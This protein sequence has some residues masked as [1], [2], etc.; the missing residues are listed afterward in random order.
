MTLNRQWITHADRN[1]WLRQRS[2]DL[3]STD[4]A[5]L[6]GFSPYGRS[7]FDLWHEK[8][9][10]DV[11]QI[12]EDSRMRRGKQ[13]ERAIAEMYASDY[14]KQY[15]RASDYCRIPELRIGSSFDF[16]EI[17]GTGARVAIWECKNVDYIAFKNG[18]TVTDDFIEAPPYIEF[19]VQH[20]MLVS[21]I[22]RAVI[23]ALI[24]GNDLRVLER[25]ADD[26]V[27]REIIARA[28]KFWQ[29]VDA[30]E[31]PDPVFP[32][33]AESFIRQRAYAE[34]GRLLDLRDDPEAC[35]LFAAFNAKQA[36][37][38][39]AEL[40]RDTAKARLIERTGDA[41]T[42][43]FPN[44]TWSAPMIAPSEGTLITPDMVGQRYGQRAGF[45]RFQAYLKKD[46][47]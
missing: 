8:R 39:A 35:A 45:R 41:E 13:M 31:P 1:E 23:V 34:P 37:V 6:F 30:N 4:C 10:G 29:S 22:S 2:Q 19:Q 46:A 7:Y 26:A 12:T 9:H 42:A 40:E 17:N 21:G 18:W 3:T 16:F 47:S 5:C 44:G 28:A 38:K 27:H 11:G 15:A 20:Q 14:E 25:E 32:G 43:I 24:G 33:D 36:A